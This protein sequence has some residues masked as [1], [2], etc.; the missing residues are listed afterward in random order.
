ME[1]VSNSMSE[2]NEVRGIVET[3]NSIDIRPRETKN[4]PAKK[5]LGKKSLFHPLSLPLF[6]YLSCFRSFSSLSGYGHG[7]DPV[8][9][10]SLSLSHT[11]SSSLL[12]LSVFSFFPPFSLPSLQLVSLR[13]LSLSLSLSLSV[14]SSLSFYKSNN[15]LGAL[16]T[17]KKPPRSSLSLSHLSPHYRLCVLELLLVSPVDQ[18]V[19][20]LP[21]RVD[22]RDR[23][24]QRP[25]GIH[26]QGVQEEEED[27]RRDCNLLQTVSGEGRERGGG[28]KRRLGR[29]RERGEKG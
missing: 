16:T 17:P 12:S 7:F 21:A 10:L 3:L 27:V 13:F 18:A 1:I 26:G 6:L 22:V 23:L 11:H 15:Y 8:S 28:E 9:L 2:W 14:F 25:P 5:C 20:P 4:E 19:G 24:G 29:E